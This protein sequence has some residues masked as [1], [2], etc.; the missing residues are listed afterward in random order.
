MSSTVD[1]PEAEKQGEG[2]KKETVETVVVRNQEL[3]QG[4]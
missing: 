4:T 2:K 3:H 1:V